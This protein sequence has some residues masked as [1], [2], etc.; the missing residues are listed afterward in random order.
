MHLA[1]VDG[2]CNYSHKTILLV[3]AKSVCRLW[4]PRCKDGQHVLKAAGLT[5]HGLKLDI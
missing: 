3:A 1:V 2:S 4:A 5:A